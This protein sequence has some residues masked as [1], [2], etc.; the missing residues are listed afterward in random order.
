MCHRSFGEDEEG[1]DQVFDNALQDLIERAPKLVSTDAQLLLRDRYETSYNIFNHAAPGP[2]GGH[3]PLALVLQHWNEDT[4]T[5]GPLRE[6][7]EQYLDHQILKHFGLS[8]EEFL[9]NPSYKCNLL[10]KI[11]AERNA[12]DDRVTSDIINDLDSGLKPQG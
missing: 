5:D 8:L 1:E 12:K 3:H 2:M 9:D 10:L 4:V 11:A 7:V 6:R